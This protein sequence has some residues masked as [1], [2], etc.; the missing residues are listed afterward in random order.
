MKSNKIVIKNGN[1]IDP[2]SGINEVGDV[3]IEN[4]YIIDVLPLSNETYSSDYKII[5]AKN[6]LV[7]PGFIDLHTHLRDPG[8]EWKQEASAKVCTYPR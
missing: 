4:S 7:T 8:Q 3:V 5:N 1:I 2:S 6:M